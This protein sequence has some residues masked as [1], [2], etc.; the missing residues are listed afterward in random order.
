M[1]LFYSI[2][3]PCFFTQGAS[4]MSQILVRKLG[5][6]AHISSLLKSPNLSLQKKALSLLANMSRTSCL[7][8]S[9]GKEEKI[10]NI[11]VSK[12]KSCRY[13]YGGLVLLSQ[14]SRYYRISSAGFQTLVQSPM[15]S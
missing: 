13:N 7:Q 9:M 12:E 10:P 6:L 11:R 15:M 8:T 14:Q 3:Y 4:A 5:A 1:V 2:H